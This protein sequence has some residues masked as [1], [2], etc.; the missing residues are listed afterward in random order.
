MSAQA[1]ITNEDWALLQEIVRL[2]SEKFED[3]LEIEDLIKAIEIIYLL[4]AEIVIM[5]GSSM[6]ISLGEEY[7]NRVAI[8][9]SFNLSLFTG[10]NHFCTW[11]FK[12]KTNEQ[13]TQTISPSTES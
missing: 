9:D 11:Y 1:P 13:H 4:G 12:N 5:F 2:N 8:E 3:E 10:L 6:Y 7:F